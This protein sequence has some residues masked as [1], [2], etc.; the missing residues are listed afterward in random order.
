MIYLLDTDRNRIDFAKV[1]GLSIE[2]WS[3]E[4]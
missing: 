1:P 4:S 3:R 2:D